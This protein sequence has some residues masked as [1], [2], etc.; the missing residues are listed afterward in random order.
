MRLVDSDKILEDLRLCKIS[1]R[2]KE[3]D[4]D[5]VMRLVGRTETEKAIPVDYI[6]QQINKEINEENR[7]AKKIGTLPTTT[8]SY[9]YSKLIEKWKK[10]NDKENAE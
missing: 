10:E 4:I 9:A 3:I 2:G 5:T 7:I 6:W 1:M 8:V